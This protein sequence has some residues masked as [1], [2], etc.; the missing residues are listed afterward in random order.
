MSNKNNSQD[1]NNTRLFNSYAS[2]LGSLQKS[3]LLVLGFG[4]FFFLMILLPYFSLKYDTHNLSPVSKIREQISEVFAEFENAI[5]SIHNTNNIINQ[6]LNDTAKATGEASSYYR[7]LETFRYL[8]S[9]SKSIPD[10]VMEKLTEIQVFPQCSKIPITSGNWSTCNFEMKSVEVKPV[11]DQASI[12]RNKATNDLASRLNKTILDIDKFTANIRS[13]YVLLKPDLKNVKGILSNV[14]NT[15]VSI[16]QNLEGASKGL[17]V[18]NLEINSL[19]PVIL[20]A[21][22]SAA[23][24]DLERS[25]NELQ[26]EKANLQ[27]V[28]DNIDNSTKKLSSG[29]EQIETPIVGK[30][31]IGF[32]EA[33]ATF[34]IGLSIGFLVCCTFLSQSISLR[35]SIHNVYKYSDMD[36]DIASLAPLWVEPTSTKLTQITQLIIFSSPFLIFAISVAVIFDIWI[37]IGEDIFRFAPILNRTLYQALYIASFIPCAIGI[38]LVVKALRDYLFCCGCKIKF[39]NRHNFELHEVIHKDSKITD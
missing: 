22:L 24:T 37:A 30:L 12:R 3:F 9:Q 5:N 29:L 21:S 15:L 31:P 19:Q 2:K 1:D 27:R 10:I 7:E 34:P 4:L 17:P 32:E 18:N 6:S 20:V 33:I 11:I 38:L 35:S 25:K 23:S 39:E 16:R 28:W 36:I 26:E 8:T 13:A 14:T